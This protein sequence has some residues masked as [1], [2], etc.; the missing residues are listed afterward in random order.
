[1]RSNEVFPFVRA[2]LG[3]LL[4]LLLVQLDDQLGQYVCLGQVETVRL[5]RLPTHRIGNITHPDRLVA[6][7]HEELPGSHEHL[8]SK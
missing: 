3:Q 1:M 5:N 2:Q 7:L 6:P 4:D 8:L